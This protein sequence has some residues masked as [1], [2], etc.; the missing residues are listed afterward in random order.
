[1]NKRAVTQSDVAERAGVSRSI[2][3]YV[4]NDGPRPVAESTR[5]RVMEAIEELGYR[6][7]EHAQRLRKGEKAASKSIGVVTGGKS[8]DVLERPYYNRVLAGL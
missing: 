3:S 4:L 2:V 6:P 7:N 8:Y 1:M 5:E